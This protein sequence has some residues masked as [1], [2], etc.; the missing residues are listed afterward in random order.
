MTFLKFYYFTFLRHFKN[1]GDESWDPSF[2]AVLLVELSFAF[3]LLIIGLLINPEFPFGASENMVGRGTW[4]GL[5]IIILISLYRYLARKSNSEQ[6]YKTF[7]DH[8]WNT[9]T[10]RIICWIIWAVI[11]LMPVMWVVLFKGINWN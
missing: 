1:I 10:N 6:I 9:R 4:V 11:F 7:I 8:P 5:N 2:R 3:L